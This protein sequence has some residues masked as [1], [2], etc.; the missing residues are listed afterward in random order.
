MKWKL[1]FLLD[2][3][4]STLTIISAAVLGNR[5]IAGYIPSL[6]DNATWLSKLVMRGLTSPDALA[7]WAL[8][9][10][11]RIATLFLFGAFF[12][13]EL[14]LIIGTPLVNR[15]IAAA[16][17]RE[18]AQDVSATYQFMSKNRSVIRPLRRRLLGRVTLR[19]TA[20]S[21]LAFVVGLFAALIAWGVA[22]L[23]NANTGGIVQTTAI[24]FAVILLLF[25]SGFLSEIVP[26]AIGDDNE[27]DG[28]RDLA[29]D[30]T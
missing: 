10:L 25:V 4:F 15:L 6:H 29:L 17:A 13:A 27:V 1:L 23:I 21:V 2:M 19:V 12:L 22:A 24:V 26:A 5:L 28:I 8:G 14:L 18:Y 16:I 11:P 9:A 20:L 7:D 3:A 30:K